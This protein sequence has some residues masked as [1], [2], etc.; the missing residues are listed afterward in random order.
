MHKTQLRRHR[1]G[2]EAA[3]RRRPESGVLESGGLGSHF[4]RTH[5]TQQSVKFTQPEARQPATY[6]LTLISLLTFPYIIMV[7]LLLVLLLLLAAAPVALSSFDYQIGNDK[8]IDKANRLIECFCGLF[9]ILSDYGFG[10][11]HHPP[12]SCPSQYL[13]PSP[14]P[15]FTRQVLPARSFLEPPDPF[16]PLSIETVG[17]SA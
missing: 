6:L 1:G 13:P 3:A 2:R 4:R 15:P 9:V 7:A 8:I 10:L 5:E 17:H 16:D 14:R 11:A 12:F